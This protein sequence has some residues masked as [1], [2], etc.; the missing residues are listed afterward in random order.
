MKMRYH[1]PYMQYAK[2]RRQ[3]PFDLGGSNILA[4]T[5]DD[6]PGAREAL[7]LSGAN[8]SGYGP[9]LDAI[10]ARYAAP[11]S[12]ITTA[13]GTAGANFLAF[14]ALLE[15]DDDVLVEMPGYDPLL[16]AI[17]LLGARPVRFERRFEDGFALDPDRVRAAMT[18]RTRLVVITHPHN[19]SG[20]AAADA[21]LDEVGR[22]AERAGAKVLVDEVYRDI[23]PAAGP[24]LALRSDVFVTTSSLTKS[25]GL[26]SLRCGWIIGSEAVIE[27]ARRARDVVDG[28]GSIV[29]ERL[30]VVAFQHL[31]ALA[32]RAQAHLTRNKAMVDA[33]LRGQPRLESAASGITVVFPRISGVVDSGR[34][35]D[36]LRE[37]H[38]TAVI[39]GHFFDAPAHFRLGYGG[40]TEPLRTGLDRIAEALA[41]WQP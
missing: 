12:R 15:P 33:F 29:A 35:V 7:A 6:L 9:L 19:P 30:A 31:G 40:A 10:A 5:L 34:F 39:P 25:Y 20:V 17:R 16:G 24:P 13:T 2:T 11:A 1:A 37:R 14:A 8:D 23:S 27:R 32:A 3:A 41:T 36:D 18:P 26:S 28:T 4:C 38:Q 21:A 22:I